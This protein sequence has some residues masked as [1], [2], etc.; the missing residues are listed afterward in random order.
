M[1]FDIH[2]YNKL[3]DFKYIGV[4]RVSGIIYFGGTQKS[5]IVIL[6]AHDPQPFISLPSGYD[7]KRVRIRV[8]VSVR[9]RVRVSVEV[10]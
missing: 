1:L 5:D 7:S 3:V 10:R 2:V 4:R 9:F 8:R 6:N